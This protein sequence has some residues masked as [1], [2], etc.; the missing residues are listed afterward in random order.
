MQWKPLQLARVEDLQTRIAIFEWDSFFCL[1]V[2]PGRVFISRVFR[3]PQHS[4]IWLEKLK[5]RSRL[6][7]ER[8][9]LIW[10]KPLPTRLTSCWKVRH[11]GALR[12]PVGSRKEKT[13]PE[14]RKNRRHWKP[15][16]SAALVSDEFPPTNSRLWLNFEWCDE[17][18]IRLFHSIF[19]YLDS[20]VHFFFTNEKWIMTEFSKLVQPSAV[21]VH[22]SVDVHFVSTWSLLDGI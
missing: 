20:W 5:V 11:F 10:K 3:P 2:D 9:P 21:V 8:R 16:A 7:A 14:K 19:L 22:G 13:R 17:F 4:N 1:P 18:R 6:C 12:R 15:P